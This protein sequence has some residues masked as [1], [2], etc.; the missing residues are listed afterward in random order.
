MFSALAR[1]VH[2][3]LESRAGDF[4]CQIRYGQAG[5]VNEWDLLRTRNMRKFFHFHAER[6]KRDVAI[7][8]RV[9]GFARWGKPQ[10]S[11]SRRANEFL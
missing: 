2:H 1:N 8:H 9:T 11:V 5:H 4:S 3:G 10:F 6:Q 7:R